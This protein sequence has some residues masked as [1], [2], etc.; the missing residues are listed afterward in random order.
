MENWYFIEYHCKEKAKNFLKE[1]ES[2]RIAGAIKKRKHRG[3]KFHRSINRK[4]SLEWG[5][6][7]SRQI[8]E[9][10]SRLRG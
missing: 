10:V 5:Q 4:S 1:S 6:R 2:D 7:T 3:L 8:D 9:S